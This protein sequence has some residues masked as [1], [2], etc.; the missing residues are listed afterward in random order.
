MIMHIMC[1]DRVN[2]TSM[3]DLPP[4]WTMKNCPITIKPTMNMK[5]K[6]S[7]VWVKTFTSFFP[8]FLALKK[9]KTWRK[10]K[11]LKKSVK[12]TPFSWFQAY[13]GRPI[14]VWTPNIST[15]LKRT[16]IRIHICHK[17]TTKI[18][19]HICEVIIL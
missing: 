18:V 19:L 13:F 1:C 4:N 17:A 12:W 11:M 14:E 5:R 15:P 3:N 10:T 16:T 7:N 9:L 2:G 6:L 8:S